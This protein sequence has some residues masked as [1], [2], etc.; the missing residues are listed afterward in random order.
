[1]TVRAFQGINPTLG[2]DVYVDPLALVLG[3]VHLG[4]DCSVWPGTIIRGDVHRIRIGERCNI[5]DGSVLHVT[6]AGKFTADGYPLILGN[7]I[8]VGHQAM[9][10][11]CTLGD[12]I[13]IGM[14]AT[15]MDA[16]VVPDNVVIGAGSMVT[17][18]KVLESGF[19]YV[20]SPAKKVRALSEKE[21]SFF[22]YSSNSYVGL[23]N[24]YLLEN[25]IQ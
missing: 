3:D 25:Y 2:K 18:G 20:G 23:K 17:P 5:Q 22:V 24:T 4:N 9:L 10:H 15:V 14:G 19:L 21:I 11:G 6:H 16:A 8:T 13:L 12:R 1:M 7:D